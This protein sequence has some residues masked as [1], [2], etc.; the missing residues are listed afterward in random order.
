MTAFRSRPINACSFAWA[1]ACLW[2]LLTLTCLWTAGLGEQEGR[3]DGSAAAAKNATSSQPCTFFCGP[4][5]VVFVAENDARMPEAARRIEVGAIT[6]ILSV[7]R[8]QD[9]FALV[10]ARGPL[11]EIRFNAGRDAVRN[12]AETLANAPEGKV[13]G[14][15]TLDAMMEAI[16]WLEPREP[17]DAIFLFVLDLKGRHHARFSKV[18]KSAV[19]DRIRVFAFQ[20]DQVFTDPPDPLDS[21][22]TKQIETGAYAM[23]GVPPIYLLVHATEGDLEIENTKHGGKDYKLTEERLDY[24]TLEAHRWYGWVVAYDGPLWH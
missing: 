4:R 2:Y 9:S 12:G 8:A 17:G 15:G 3:T 23:Q 18:Q 24:L 13:E 10:T 6:T 21:F 1:H 11:E 20:L 7:A 16:T 14:Q 19:R 5:R 22:T